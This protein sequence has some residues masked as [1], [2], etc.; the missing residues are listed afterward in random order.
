MIILED[1]SPEEREKYVEQK[2]KKLEA[3]KRANE[4][5]GSKD[6]V[7]YRCEQINVIKLDGAINAHSSIKTEYLLKFADHRNAEVILT[8]SIYNFFTPGTEHLVGFISSIDQVKGRMI[9]ELDE[10]GK[11]KK[12]LNIEELRKKWKD[13]KYEFDNN[14]FMKSLTQKAK[15]QVTEAGDKEFLMNNN[16]LYLN[17]NANL[18]NQV[19][20]GQYL[21]RNYNDFEGE[22]LPNQS[23]FFPDIKFDVNCEIRKQM[24]DD[25]TITYKKIGK[26]SF[27]DIPQMIDLYD[28]FYKK[29]LQYKFTDYKYLLEITYTVSKKDNRVIKGNVSIEEAIINNMESLVIYDL[30]QVQL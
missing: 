26:P 4:K 18:F 15:D 29:Q 5:I 28:R 19:V 14:P 12:I 20:F 25:E 6:Q 23:H 17:A 13:Y 24:E 9:Y 11:I 21:K 8:D 27:I 3:E 2:R 30:K 16:I 10:K 1:L 7:R 22:V